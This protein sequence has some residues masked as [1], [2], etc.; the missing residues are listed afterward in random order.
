MATA[1]M[2]T[3]KY[4]TAHMGAQTVSLSCVA[5][6]FLLTK[7]CFVPAVTFYLFIC[8]QTMKSAIVGSSQGIVVCVFPAITLKVKLRAM[9]HSLRQLYHICCR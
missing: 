8:I 7:E 6:I 4:W 9:L 2:T 1:P 5:F 3:L